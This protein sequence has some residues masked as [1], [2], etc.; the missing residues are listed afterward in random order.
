M[1]NEL[2][3]RRNLAAKELGV[4][5]EK[6]KTIEDSVAARRRLWPDTAEEEERRHQLLRSDSVYRNLSNRYKREGLSENEK[7]EAFNQKMDR[8]H[9]IM[10]SPNPE[11]LIVVAK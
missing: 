8:L 2:S 9:E 11:D 5:A 3:R 7:Q 10:T 1:E 6:L 4:A